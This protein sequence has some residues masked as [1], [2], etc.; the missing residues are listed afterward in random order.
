MD[1][2]IKRWLIVLGVVLLIGLIIIALVLG[3]FSRRGKAFDSRPLVLIHEPNF[4]GQFR[5]GDGVIVHATA[6]E[7][8]GL[9]RIELWINDE[10]VDLYEAEDQAT[11]NLVLFSTWIPTYEGEH[12]IIVRATSTDGISGQSSIHINAIPAS[13]GGT[14]VHLVEEGDTLDSIAEEYG[15][16]PDEI[17]EL[18]P[19]IGDGGLAPGDG[20]V[21]PDGEPESEDESPSPESDSEA[22]LW[23]PGPALVD[24]PYSIFDLIPSRESPIVLRLEVPRLQ[25]G[26]SFDGLHCYVGMAESLPQWYPDR[27]GDQST[28]ESFVALGGGWWNTEDFLVG[29]TAPLILWQHDE[30]LPATINCVGETGGG[31]EIVELG[32]IALNFLPEQ[33]NGVRRSFETDGEG[34]HLLVE[35]RVSRL[36]E[37][38]RLTP[39]YLDPFMTVPTNPQL[40]QETRAFSW[41]YPEEEEE[42]IIGFEIFL[43]GNL[44]WT[45]GA[46]KRE[47][48]MPAEWFNPPCGSTYIFGVRAYRWDSDHWLFAQSRTAEIELPQP[49]R[50]CT[51]QLQITFLSLETFSLPGDGS[52][53]DRLGDIGPAY[54]SFFANDSRFSF[55]HGREGSGAALDRLEGLSHN[56]F[57]DLAVA[58]ANPGWNTNGP[59]VVFTDLPEGNTLWVGFG[60]TDR[61]TGSC[62]DEGDPGCDDFICGAVHA[63]LYEEIVNFDEIFTSTVRSANGRC[64]V[65]FEIRPGPDSP[66]GTSGA[67]G[68]PLPWLEFEDFYLNESTGELGLYLKNTGTAGWSLRDLTVGLRTRDGDMITDVDF[69]SIDI[70]VDDTAPLFHPDMT[71]PPPYDFCVL[72]DPYDEVLELHER[73]GFFSHTLE[74]PELPDLEVQGVSYRPGSINRIR[75]EVQNV[76][77]ADLINRTLTVDVRRLDDNSRLFES[78]QI[79]SV[80]IRRGETEVLDI[81]VP[82]SSIRG[83]MAA[84]YKVNLNPG[85]TVIES[86]YGNNEIFVGEAT[87]LSVVLPVINVP[88]RDPDNVE[89][90]IDGYLRNGRVRTNHV[91]DFVID[92]N[93][94]DWDCDSA[95]G[96]CSGVFYDSEYW[97]DWFDVYGDQVLEFDI[98]Y[99]VPGFRGRGDMATRV[100]FEPPTWNGGAFDAADGSCHQ[101]FSRYIGSNAVVIFDEDG[102]RWRTVIDVCR[103]NY[104]EE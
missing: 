50:G 54:G 35:V 70:P 39:K 95:L 78:V 101:D 52:Y 36:M 86:D 66:I 40:D 1:K 12:Q 42:N 49:A 68:E 87:R 46:F 25:T 28:G 82:D 2:S 8:N 19:G 57:Y 58:V 72:I 65:R 94:V 53:E 67:G 30:A 43:N 31:T 89:I 73:S 24:S 92:G 34:G 77:A 88:I 62:D 14:G 99:D 20:I 81:P 83:E 16:S 56:T 75:L 22:P 85:N 51:R 41:E 64:D 4:D 76:G 44:L 23:S 15:S 91:V 96:Q 5:V 21:V 71:I 9:S 103:E 80:N 74:C 32:T 45:E 33:W 18:N 63:P 69:L 10:Q 93:D 79:P 61:D 60:I 13:E 48:R 27:D 26:S 47:S 84:G 7:D 100:V 6:R 102:G 98:L 97:A 59:N 104:G 29:D 11:T 17:E 37:S 90:Q 38:S 3:W 55:D